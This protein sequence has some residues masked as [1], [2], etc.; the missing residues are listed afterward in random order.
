MLHNINCITSSL[1]GSYRSLVL[2]SFTPRHRCAQRIARIPV[3]S[4]L[5][6]WVKCPVT[7]HLVESA[8][9]ITM[10]LRVQIFPRGER[11]LHRHSESPGIEL[12]KTVVELNLK[13]T[14]HN[15]TDMTFH[16]RSRH[17]KVWMEMGAFFI[18]QNTRLTCLLTG[19]G[20]RH[21]SV[22]GSFCNAGLTVTDLHEISDGVQSSLLIGHRAK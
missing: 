4:N 13:L 22:D 2:S 8:T 21:W 10:N 17:Q 3:S 16:R 1:T 7:Y 14:C 15:C 20:H 19:Y 18:S 9:C 6:P 5:H 12:H 11:E